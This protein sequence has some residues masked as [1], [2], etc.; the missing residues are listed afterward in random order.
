MNFKIYLLLIPVALLGCQEPQ[1]SSLAR[2]EVFCEMVANDA[3]PL[4]LSDPMESEDLNLKWEEIQKIASEYGVLVMRESNFPVTPLFPAEM[5]EYKEVVVIYKNPRWVQYQ[6]L[7]T[8]LEQISP[9]EAARRMGRLLGYSPKGINS[10]LMKNSNFRTLESFGVNQQITHLYYEDLGEAQSFYGETLGLKADLLGRFQIGE[11]TFLDLHAFDADHPEGQPKSTAIAFLTDQLPL[12]YAYVQE[13]GVPIKYTYKP[14][15]GGP[16]DG[17]VAIDPGGYLLEFEQFKQHPENELFMAVL[18]DAPWMETKIRPLSFYG[19]ITWT[20][21][22]DLLKMQNFYEQ[23][24]GFAMVAD[25][26]WTK[27]FQTS[28]SGFI[29]L[30]DERRGMMDYADEKAV[31]IEWT[32]RDSD[33]ARTYFSNADRWN[34]DEAYLVGPE[35]YRYRIR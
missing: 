16:H 33:A 14:R 11:N 20:Y 27:I 3:K 13:K 29:G 30:V 34:S 5:T 26:G 8:D 28:H 17:F 25:Q 24:L 31:E 35:K 18:Q 22:R 10:L 32:L 19:S 6:H 4:A 15:D 21:H 9:E 7:K 12:W 1:P 23:E 2:F